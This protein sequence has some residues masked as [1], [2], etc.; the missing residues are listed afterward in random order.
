MNS[1]YILKCFCG[2]IIAQ[3]RCPDINKVVSVE[4]DGCDGC[5]R[6]KGEDIPHET[7]EEVYGE[8]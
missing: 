7:Q 3:C 2:A 5:R 8:R 4:K 6:A 1:H